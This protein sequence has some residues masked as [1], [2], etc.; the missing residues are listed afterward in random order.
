MTRINTIPPSELM[1]EHLIAEYRELPRIFTLT[2]SAIKRGFTP[3]TYNIPKT[4]KLGPGHMKFFSNKLL[5]LKNR[6]DTIVSEMY[7][8]GFKVSFPEPKIDSAIPLHWFNDLEPNTNDLE[9]SRQ[10][11]Q[12]RLSQGKYHYCGEVL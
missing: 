10:R 4:F 1:D 5:W 9:L 6:Y 8:R 2:S 12:E 7:E 11:I 3:Q